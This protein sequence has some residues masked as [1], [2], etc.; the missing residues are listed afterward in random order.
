MTAIAR[1]VVQPLVREIA[2]CDPQQAF[3]PFAQDPHAVLLDLGEPATPESRYAYLCLSPYATQRG[4]RLVTEAD[5]F[6]ALA[7]SLA[8][9]DWQTNSDSDLPPFQGGICGFLSYECGAWLERLP[10]PKPV[11]PRLPLWSLSLYDL[12]VACDR[13]Q[14]RTWIFSSGLPLQDP[15]DRQQRAEQRLQWVCDRLQSALPSQSPDWQPQADWQALQ[16]EADFCQAVDQVKCHIRAGDI[17]QANLTTAFRASQPKDLSPWQLYRRLYQLS[18]EPFSAYFAGG[19]FQ[20]LSVSP[21]RFLRL[22]RDGWVET[23]PI[24]GTRPRSADPAHDRQLATELQASEKDRAENVMIVDLLRNDLG[25]VCRPRSIQVP[26]LCQL[27]SYEH[28]HHLTSQVIGQL[29]S[30][31]TAVDLLRATFPGGSIT[32]APKI[33][34]ME[35]IHELEP[36][37]RQAYCG[38]LFWLGFDG[39]LD[40]SI[41]I[42]TL[43]ISQGQVLA[44]AGCGIVA[45]S[46]PLDE[47]AEMQVKVQ[48]LLRSL[49]PS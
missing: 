36:I 4:D 34:S 22:D 49:Q 10:T 25:R 12:V 29:R 43:Q 13:Q 47:C 19:D 23:R 16:T 14:R 40:A 20:L 1:R 9:V 5:P 32:G 41:L 48:P 37:P 44:Q 39:S 30:G 2:W 42:R 33:R 15:R 3:A 38:S 11:E 21:E 6:Q 7:T 18:P 24:K 31:L 45:D 28:V 46:D 27:E 17:F 35:I 26:Q 8:T